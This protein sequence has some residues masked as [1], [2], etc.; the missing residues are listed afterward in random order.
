MWMRDYDNNPWIVNVLNA[1]ASLILMGIVLAFTIVVYFLDWLWMSGP[2]N[3][4]V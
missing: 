4:R 2:S 1:I 3:K